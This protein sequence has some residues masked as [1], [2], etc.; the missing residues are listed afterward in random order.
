VVLLVACGATPPPRQPLT[1]EQQM[2][3]AAD[4]VIECMA[5]AGS[6]CLHSSPAADAWAA[7]LELEHIVTTP[8]PLLPNLLLRA[9]DTLTAATEVQRRVAAETDRA[10][11]L[12]RD[13]SCKV[14]GVR[15]VGAELGAR[16]AA[17]IERAEG[18][19]LGGTL[20]GSAAGTLAAAAEPLGRTQLV[21]ARC[22]QGTVYVLI[23][24]PRGD[25]DPDEDPAAH[26]G[27]GWE[28]FVAS[29]DQARLLRGHE[30]LEH[31]PRII[32]VAPGD[33][34]DPWIPITEVDL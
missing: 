34:L 24:P 33:A 22:R 11:P 12:T 31:A 14:I 27:G 21:E 2:L 16:R 6:S 15:D 18:L 17:L 26:A 8:A 32:D 29:H 30:P 3:A 5:S 23:S 9:A 4:A 7:Q 1:P 25:L 20:A 13:L 28:A 19:G 10:V